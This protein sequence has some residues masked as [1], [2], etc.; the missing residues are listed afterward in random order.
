[1]AHQSPEFEQ[2]DVLGTTQHYNG[3]VGLVS[4]LVPAVAG[5]KISNV[6]VRS[7]ATN[8]VSSVLYVAFDGQSVFLSLK[9]GEFAAWS[10]KN[11]QSNNPISQIRV[12]GSSA[13]VAYEIIVDYEP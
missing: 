12:L 2:K 9:R 5:K 7:P 11:D 3:S 1:M 4:S 10:P 13:S 8:S 6:L